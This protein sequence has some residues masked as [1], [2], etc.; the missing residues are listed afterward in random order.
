MRGNLLTST[1]LAT[2][3]DIIANYSKGILAA[4]DAKLAIAHKVAGIIVLKSWWTRQLDSVLPTIEALPDARSRCCS[5][6]TL[7]NLSRWRPYA[8]EPTF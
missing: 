5:C 8:E 7:R 2:P 4:E 6:R 3:T 1:L